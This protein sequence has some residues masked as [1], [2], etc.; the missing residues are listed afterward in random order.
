MNAEPGVL[1]D[2]FQRSFDAELRG[3]NEIPESDFAPARAVLDFVNASGIGARAF[4]TA[5]ALAFACLLL[6]VSSLGAVAN[7][8]A[9]TPR[10]IRVVLDNAYAPFSFRTDTGQLQGI[11]IDQWRAWEKQTGIKVEIHAVNWGEAVRRMRAGEFDVIDSIVETVERRDYFDFTPGYAETKTPIFFRNDIS[12]IVDL[13]S[14]KGYPVAVKA[15]DQHIDRLMANGVTAIIPFQNNDAII[16]AAKRHEIDVFVA[17]APS[18]L[19]LLHKAGIESEFRSS[20]PMFRDE[21]K[22][23]VRKGDADLLRTVTTGF[24]AIDPAELKRIDERWFGRT[25][26]RYGRYLSFAGYA[27]ASALLLIA[28]LVVWNRAL[29][30]MILQRTAALGESELCFRQIAEN[31]HEVFWLT[32]GDLNKIL[33]VSPA[34]AAIWGRSCESLYQDSRSFIAAIHPE[35]RP[36]VIEAIERD[37]A[38]GFDVEYRVV[39]P[40]GSIRWIR[41]RG[42][43]IK[44]EAAHTYRTAGIAEDITERKL[45]AE[46]EKQADD[47]VRLI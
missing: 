14:L 40:D 6:A 15:G 11:L 23:A 5:A 32:T 44:D 12:G 20:A 36:Q 39:R 3:V 19:Y 2:N 10:T 24:A 16:A 41:D 26:D 18:A 43:P 47:H 31:I 33:Y 29:R 8:A 46:T 25:L 42:F 21:L 22:R 45:A 27:T 28:G 30:K 34:Y 1:S 37:R 4:R 9:G 13:A 35:D 38:H 17:D 7:P